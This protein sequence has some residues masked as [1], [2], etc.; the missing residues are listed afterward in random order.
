EYNESVWSKNWARKNEGEKGKKDKGAS[1][2]RRVRTAGDEPP[3]EGGEGSSEDASGDSGDEE[4]TVRNDD[5][6]PIASDIDP[7]KDLDAVVRDYL[8]AALWADLTADDDQGTPLDN[9]GIINIAPES[10][11]KAK[12]EVA[13]FEEKAGDLLDGLDDGQVGHDIWLSRNGHGAGFFDRGYGEKGDKLQDMA[14][15]MGT[16]HI[17][18]GDDGKVYID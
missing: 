15:D 17:Y 10:I 11:E 7:M 13:D 4:K 16:A 18:V 6:P 12:K 1:S 14:R 8:V 9:Y 2:L 3:E 5:D